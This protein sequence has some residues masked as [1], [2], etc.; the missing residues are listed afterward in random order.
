MYS[1]C[2]LQNVC[3]S[4]KWVENLRMIWEWFEIPF[5]FNICRLL[6]FEPSP[7][8]FSDLLQDLV[9]SSFTE[10]SVCN[11]CLHVKWPIFPIGKIV[12]PYQNRSCCPDN[13]T[14]ALQGAW[15]SQEAMQT[16]WKESGLRKTDTKRRYYTS[17]LY[18]LD[19]P[20]TQSKVQ[21]KSRVHGPTLFSVQ[22]DPLTSL[23]D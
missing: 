20:Q 19:V 18:N 13:T 14:S 5:C 17:L 22:Q 11:G 23:G 21:F 1:N 8:I 6:Y 9:S 12:F 2:P 4:K 15:G 10:Q 16:S 3:H 7:L